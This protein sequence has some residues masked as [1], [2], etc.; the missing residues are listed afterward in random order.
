MLMIDMKTLGSLVREAREQKRWNT[1][2]TAARLGIGQSTLSNIERDKFVEAPEPRVLRAIEEHLGISEQRQLVAL[3]YLKESDKPANIAEDTPAYDEL[4]GFA[5]LIATADS[6]TL[7]ELVTTMGTI[8][9][10]GAGVRL[11]YWPPFSSFLPG[12]VVDPR[13]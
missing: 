9:V 7:R 11:R 13:A 10:D 2:T 3:G 4:A 6:P 12:H 1:T 5:D 8:L